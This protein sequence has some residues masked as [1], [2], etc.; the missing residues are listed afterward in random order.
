MMSISLLLILLVSCL[1]L[2]WLRRASALRL[3][4]PLVSW[5]S[6][7]MSIMGLLFS[8]FLFLLF[9]SRHFVI[10]AFA[11]TAT[12]DPCYPCGPAPCERI[13]LFTTPTPGSP[14]GVECPD[15]TPVGY[16]T[17][18]PDAF[19]LLQCAD[20]LPNLTPTYAWPTINPGP[21]LDPTL[22][23]VTPTTTTTPTIAPT[24][25]LTR[26]IRC[27]SVNGGA[28]CPSTDQAV[29]T[30]S[31]SL[32]E[33]SA[34]S[35]NLGLFSA[36]VV[37]SSGNPAFD[38]PVYTRH[39]G[40][41]SINSGTYATNLTTT[42]KRNESVI[43]TNV[44]SIPSGDNYTNEPYSLNCVINPLGVTN[45][46][47]IS[48]IFSPYSYSRSGKN[49]TFFIQV[50]TDPTFGA[51]T[52]T[53]TPGPS[54]CTAIEGEGGG[55]DGTGYPTLWLGPSDCFE[56]P[57][58][59]GEA[60]GLGGLPLIGP[61]IDAIDFAGVEFCVQEFGMTDLEFLGVV[62]DPNILLFVMAGALLFRIFLRS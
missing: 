15:G 42:A 2:R 23:P 40:T 5:P 24:P 1:G 55:D 12:S 36:L 30:V 51:A 53:P 37:N 20:C 29:L 46:I 47:T 14:A 49:R 4:L 48:N 28:T 16:G 52:P 27:V 31:G 62:I 8:C 43:C 57:A 22:Y 10:D 17:V 6:I 32:Y 3:S 33:G 25:A 35:T 60:L 61:W 45:A 7:R 34:S 38:V 18:T 26:L 13:C 50:S 9:F 59:D 56:I 41:F 11:Q 39:I 58:I 44:I 19:W 54:M 21:T